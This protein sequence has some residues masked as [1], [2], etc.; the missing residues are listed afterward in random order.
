MQPVDASRTGRGESITM[1]AENKHSNGY[2]N[3]R[4]AD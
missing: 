4:Y 1:H 3:Y 2:R